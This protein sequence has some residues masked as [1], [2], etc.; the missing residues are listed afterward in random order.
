MSETAAYAAENG[1]YRRGDL[2]M[3]LG[4]KVAD[5]LGWQPSAEVYAKE[6]LDGDRRRMAVSES[7]RGPWRFW[8][9]VDRIRP[10]SRVVGQ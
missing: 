9:Q 4:D 5:S 3:T 6:V 1:T 7:S 10:G 8:T 2:G